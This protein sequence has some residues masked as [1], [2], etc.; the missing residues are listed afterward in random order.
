MRIFHYH[1]Y[2]YFLIAV[3]DKFPVKDLYLNFDTLAIPEL[4]TRQLLIYLFI[5]F[6]HH[7]HLLP[8]AFANYFTSISTIHQHNTREKE[9][10]L[11]TSVSKDFGKRSVK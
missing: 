6:L 9:N 1:Y 10:L 5:I 3:I 11:L 8:T 2:Y 4:H 7:P